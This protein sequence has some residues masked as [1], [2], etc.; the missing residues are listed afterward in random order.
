MT[1]TGAAA[2][3]GVRCGRWPG[4]EL[5]TRW[6]SLVVV[7]L[8]AGLV[9][10]VVGASTAVARRTATA[11]DRLAAATHLD[12]A[13]VLIFSDAVTPEEVEALPGVESSWRS[14]QVIGQVVGGPVT[15]LSVS[16]GQPQPD[17][18]FTPVVIEGRRAG[19]RPGR[20]GDGPRGARARRPGSR[21]GDRIPLKLLT[22]LEVTQFDTGFGEPDG[23]ELTL[24]VVGIV[25]VARDWVGNGVGPGAWVRRPWP[26]STRTAWS[27]RTSCCGWRTGR[28]G[29]PPWPAGWTGC[30]TG[31]RPTTPG[32][33]SASCRRSTPPPT[34]TRR[35][36]PRGTPW[37]PDWSCSSSSP[38]PAGC[39]RSARP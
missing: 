16:S 25:R 5:R 24:K 28:P 20:R 19:R 18:L 29:P 2:P 36:A 13:R 31:R 23:P 1:A 37:S 39:S 9:A 22:P 7:G 3:R 30:R 27:A 21:I 34:T 26:A 14:R 38:R 35:C 32:A 11:Y 8:L 6:R 12:D 4:A 33:S 15:F 10:A 17:D